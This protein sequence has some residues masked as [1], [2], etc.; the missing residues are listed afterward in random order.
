MQRE[1]KPATLG[2]APAFVQPV[3]VG[4]PWLPDREQ[5][6]ALIGEVL[7]S[8]QLSN[9]GPCVAELERRVAALHDVRH[10][11]AT[12]NGTLALELALRAAQLT[13]EV[14]VPSFT[15]I[16]TAHAV[17]R[18]GGARPRNRPLPAAGHCRRTRHAAPRAARRRC[19][20]SLHVVFLLSRSRD[21]I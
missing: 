4:G 12:C 11:V 14:V 2:G 19:L 20:P 3:V 21:S 8:G 6:L 7:D 18:A 16:A 1:R 5:V 15:F 9:G 10:C 17:S 13:G